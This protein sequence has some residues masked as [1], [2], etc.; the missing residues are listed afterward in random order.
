MSA[1]CRVDVYHTVLYA[2]EGILHAVVHRFGDGVRGSLEIALLVV[3][4]HE[5]PEPGLALLDAGIE[6]PIV[7]WCGLFPEK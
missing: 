5:E 3:G 6:E 7:G 1:S 2:G 4:G